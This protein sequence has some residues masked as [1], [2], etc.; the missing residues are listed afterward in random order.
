MVATP[1][2]PRP[3]ESLRVGDVVLAY[4]LEVGELVRRRIVAVRSAQREPLRIQTAA[5][6]LRVTHDHPVYFADL[7]DFADAER[8]A[9]SAN[10]MLLH[11]AD[12][13]VS[14]LA[15]KAVELPSEGGVDA[16]VEVF[17]L[18]LDAEPRNFFADGFLVH[19]KTETGTV[20]F[21]GPS[22]ES[23]STEETS[24][25]STEAT[26]TSDSSDGTGDMMTDM[27]GMTGL[28]R[29]IAVCNAVE[30]CGLDNSDC[31]AE[32]QFVLGQPMFDSCDAEWEIVS[33]CRE[34]L[35]CAELADAFGPWS[36]P[37]PCEDERSVLW[38]CAFGP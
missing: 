5:G 36:E 9:R 15:V 2:G 30:A 25:E 37:G 17:D 7:G 31:N 13:Q 33:A 12:G 21:T 6:C 32:C 27:A 16:A 35:T 10:A 20:T 4:D 19:N 14:E 22:S 3:I 26:G 8:A 23:T 11:L 34:T 1:T 18:S 29:C 28:D 24:S 38:E